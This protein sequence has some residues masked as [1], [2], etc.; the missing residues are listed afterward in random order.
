VIDVAIAGAGPAGSLAALV[1][2]RAGARVWMIDR[3]T[4]PRDKLCGDTINPGAVALLRDLDLFGGPLSDARPLRGML[5]SGPGVAIRARYPDGK[6]GLALRRRDLDAWL[7]DC[8][9]RAGARF[10][11]GLEVRAPL[12]DATSG[13][14]Q[15][16]GLVMARRGHPESTFRLPAL[17]TIAADGRRS[18]LAKALGLV[19]EQAPPRRWAFGTYASGVAGVGEL[20]EMHLR[21]GYY[22]GIAPL[23]ETCANVCV[24]TGPRPPGST[25]LEVIRHLIGAD[26]AL[27]ARF[28]RARFDWPVRVLGPLAVTTRAAG[29]DGLLLAGDAAGFVD[30]MTGD[31]LHLAMQSAR[32]AA[33]EALRALEHGTSS[34]AAERLGQSRHRLLGRKLAFNRALRRLSSSPAAL[35]LVAGGARFAPGLVRAT[36][37]YAGDAR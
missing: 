21:R 23:D 26:E 37:A 8:A 10:E 22:L 34:R 4:F 7:L 24:V 16:R 2:A 11:P 29:A 1:L 15:V 9:V 6:V 28:D 25:P 14:P 3:D 5:V 19:D 17:L 18:R 32:L 30:P 36:V 20:G 33:V 12:M 27:A 31:G 13:V 35:R